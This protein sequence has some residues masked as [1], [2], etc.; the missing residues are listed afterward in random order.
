[1]SIYE[2]QVKSGERW[3][4]ED[5]SEEYD[6][7]FERVL[8]MER[9]EQPGELRLRRVDQIR[10]GISRERTVYEGGSRI[11]QE[12]RARYALEER[13]ALKQRIQDRQSHK[14]MTETAKVEAEIEAKRQTRLQAQTHPVY[15]TLMS[16]F[17]LLLGLGAMYFVQHSLFVS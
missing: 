4:V 15:M 11:R 1:M 8:R 14:R 7:A 10:T 3:T 12:R 6:V 16:G 2:I 5:A 13:N 17:I 9:V